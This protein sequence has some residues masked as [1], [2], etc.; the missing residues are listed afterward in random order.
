VAGVKAWLVMVVT[1]SA[2]AAMVA[3][4]FIMIVVG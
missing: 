2:R 1:M 4:L 3:N